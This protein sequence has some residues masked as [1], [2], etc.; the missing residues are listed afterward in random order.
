MTSP[1]AA[2]SAALR[3]VQ[4]AIVRPARADWQHRLDLV[5]ILV[6]RYLKGLY[7]DSFLGMVW[8]VINPLAQL[9]IYVFLFRIVLSLDIPRYSSFAFTGV[10]VYTWFQSALS[11]ATSVIRDNADL[12]ALP[13]FSVPILPVISV[14]TTL[15]NFGIALPLLLLIIAIDGTTWSLS[16]TALPVLLLLQFVFTL[17]LAYLAAAANVYVRDVEHLLGV[18]LQLYFFLTPIFYALDAVPAAYQWVYTINPMAHLITAYRDVL[19][20]GTAPD[21]SVLGVLALVSMT[22]LGLGMRVFSTASRR[23]LE[24]L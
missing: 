21:W 1:L 13:G 9:L 7:K 3:S 6:Q 23:F 15:I 19:L 8:T 2:V 18:A 22:L 24:M 11:D 20:H 5:V 12:V 17:G 4:T 16:L 14:A 10:L